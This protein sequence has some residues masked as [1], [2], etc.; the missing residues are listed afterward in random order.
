METKDNLHEIISS[1]D[2]EIERL[3][4]EIRLLRK[5][6]FAPK[7]EKRIE[8]DSPQL[9]LFDMPENPQEEETEEEEVVI[10]T[11]S[12]KKKGRKPLPPHLDRFEI[13][14]DI[15]E[16]DK[17]GSFEFQVG[18]QLLFTLEKSSLPVSK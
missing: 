7:S 13:I 4:D 18:K 15:P 2:Q 5:A 8:E 17:T 10:T 3:K 12:R 6:L 1:K 14:H 9:P 16:E 11:H